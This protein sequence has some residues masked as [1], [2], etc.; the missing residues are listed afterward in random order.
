MFES[1]KEVGVECHVGVF[2]DEYFEENDKAGIIVKGERFKA[3]LLIVAVTPIHLLA[4][5]RME[6]RVKV[7]SWCLESMANRARGDMRYHL[8]NEVI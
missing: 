4:N 6:S 3:D 5:S 2:A 7:V 8:I 1:A